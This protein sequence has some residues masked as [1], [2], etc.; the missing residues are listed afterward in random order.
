[1]EAAAFDRLARRWSTATTRRR[2]VK[3]LGAAAVAGVTALRRGGEAAAGVC[4]GEDQCDGT[5][6]PS[7]N[8]TPKCRCYRR[9]GGGRVC[10]KSSTIS[11][12]DRCRRDSQCPRGYVCSSGGPACCG[13]GKRFCVKKC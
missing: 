6:S 11:C 2:F 5:G 13:T 4:A 3:G 12:N 7:C 9:V 8:G 1:M 10:G